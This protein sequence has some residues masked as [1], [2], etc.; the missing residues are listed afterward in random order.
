MPHSLTIEG[1]RF[2]ATTIFFSL[3]NSRSSISKTEYSMLLLNANALLAGIVQG[4]VVQ[5][6]ILA[7]F[8]NSF[9]VSLILKA[10]YIVFEV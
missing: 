10:T 2:L 6:I 5:I 3:K 8:K 9:L 7:S 4:V 1:I